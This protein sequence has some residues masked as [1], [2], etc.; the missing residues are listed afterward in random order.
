MNAG[1]DPLDDLAARFA[2][3]DPPRARATLRDALL[4][5]FERGAAPVR[6]LRLRRAAAM[7]AAAAAIVAVAL[8]LFRG[9]SESTTRGAVERESADELAMSE[10][11]ERIDRLR[12]D[13]D[14]FEP[15]VLAE[16]PAAPPA[17]SQAE[18]QPSDVAPNGA[19][20]S[21]DSVALDDASER[22]FAATGSDPA[23]F[24]LINARTHEAV[25][26]GDA[27]RGYHEIVRDYPESPASAAA[28]A[29]LALLAR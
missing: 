6:S 13:V 11:R 10:L 25:D 28:R 20:P 8:S 1:R 7:I 15:V 23:L 5:E 12:A 16:P 19:S 22:A 4:A 24:R 26:P 18:P 9:A 17:E 21:A 3:T 14:R 29:R 27:A 2:R